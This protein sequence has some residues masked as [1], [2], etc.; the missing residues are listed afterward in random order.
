M[1]FLTSFFAEEV[2]L[3]REKSITHRPRSK[4][5]RELEALRIQNQTL[6]DELIGFKSN[7]CFTN[8]VLL[9]YYFTNLA[10]FQ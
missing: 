5:L 7:V 3:E 8:Y 10:I 4:E 9:N 2:I 1:I 6:Q